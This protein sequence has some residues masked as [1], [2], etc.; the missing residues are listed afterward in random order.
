MTRSKRRANQRSRPPTR[1][2][3]GGAAEG[4]STTS[5][6]G[7]T[8][9]PKQSDA[10]VPLARGR[11]QT[12]GESVLTGEDIGVTSED[13]IRKRLPSGLFL[14]RCRQRTEEHAPPL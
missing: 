12:T 9:S 13:V 11:R 5:I 8:P 14:S 1:A 4:A 3:R 2:A 10:E 6:V 7:P